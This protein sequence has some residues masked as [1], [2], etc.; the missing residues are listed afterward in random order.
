MKN[1]R[2]IITAVFLLYL[3]CTLCLSVSAREQMPDEYGDYIDSIPEDIR[4][5][6][7]EGMLSDVR[8]DVIGAAERM[9]SI[10]FVMTLLLN[11]VG[12]GIAEMLPHVLCL[13]GI[14][15]LSSL[16]STMVSHLSPHFRTV[17]ICS[18]LAFFACIGWTSIDVIGNVKEYLTGLFATVASFVPL[19]G[20][21][22][23][24]GGNVS[25]AAS[26]GVGLTL[27]LSVIQFICISIAIPLFCFCMALVF[28]SAADAEINAS[29]LCAAIKKPFMSILAI[30]MSVLAV[31]LTTQTLISAK[32]DGVA[33]RGAKVLAGTQIPV[34]GGTVSATLGTVASG[35]ELL[36][37]AV[38]VGGIIVIAMSVLPMIIKLWMLRTT[39]GLI[40]GASGMLSLGGA[41]GALNSVS[42]LYGIL[43]GVCVMCAL[44]FV[45]AL[46]LFSS[47]GAALI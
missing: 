16:G 21:L 15:I 45:V 19:S 39:Y 2:I 35:V 36:R 32:A 5:G 27:T 22:Y 40:S 30:V 14:V 23:C 24:M 42:E 3:I 37:G 13:F 12:R 8:E 41:Q 20:V 18:R 34:A 38:G 9:S 10:G 47:T 7:D 28:C 11:S 43:E 4:N 33:M 29:G 31:S 25:T 6:L 44:I 1:K 46:S 26:T 17:E